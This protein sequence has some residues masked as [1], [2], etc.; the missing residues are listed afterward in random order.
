MNLAHPTKVDIT[1]DSLVQCESLSRWSIDLASL[2]MSDG[3][4]CGFIFIMVV[5]DLDGR[6]SSIVRPCSEHCIGRSTCV[7][8]VLSL[9]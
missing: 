4:V 5:S 7:C 9:F 1:R 3:S 2:A 6:R 8:C